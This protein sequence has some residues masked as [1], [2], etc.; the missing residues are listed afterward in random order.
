M[1]SR[2]RQLRGDRALRILS[3]P[4]GNHLRGVYEPRAAS[5]RIIIIDP[6]LLLVC[7]FSPSITHRPLQRGVP[8]HPAPRPRLTVLSLFSF[9]P[10]RLHRHVVPIRRRHFQFLRAVGLV[11][12]R[13]L[14]QRHLVRYA[15][16][17]L[18]SSL[19]LRGQPL[20]QAAARFRTRH[21]IASHDH[22]ATTRGGVRVFGAVVV[23]RAVPATEGR[24]VCQG[25]RR[26]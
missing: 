25:Q 4:A 7:V 18:C 12:L 1:T 13:R 21:A 9:T 19:R 22:V 2:G 8:G 10:N 15:L 24:A 17:S 11:Q 16:R 6:P 26:R 3:P 23:R 14:R 5:V 20:W